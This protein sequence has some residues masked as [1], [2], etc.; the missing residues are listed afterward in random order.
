MQNVRLSELQLQE[1]LVSALAEI[2]GVRLSAA[3]S[4]GANAA[5][6][7]EKTITLDGVVRRSGSRIRI[8][9]RAI[10]ADGSVSWSEHTDGTFDD[11]FALEDALV[12]STK[13]RFKVATRALPGESAFRSTAATPKHAP[14]KKPDSEADHLVSEGLKAFRLGPS[15]AGALRHHLEV[16]AT[17][18]KRAL[19][20]EPRNA[21]GLCAYGNL[22]YVMGVNGLLPREEAFAKG[23][24]LIFAALAADDRSAEVHS[25]LG[26]LALYFD[27]DFHAAARHIH[28]SLELDPD[29][30]EALRVQSIVYKILG[31][32]DEAIQ[33][34]RDAIARSPDVAVL[35]NALGDALL[36]AGRNAEAVDALR[37]A[38]SLA[39]SYAPAQERLEIARIRLGELELAAE[40]RASR[41]AV[42]GQRERA[43]M[44]QSET[45]ELGAAEAIQRDVKRALDA[46][47][48]QAET[49]NPFAEYFATRSLADRIVMGFAEL[50]DWHHAMDWVERAYESRPGR[51]RRMLTD[52]PFDRRGLA[53]DPRYARLLRVAS[54]DDLL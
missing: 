27:D 24:E 32:I 37:H 35:W 43:A 13:T 26:K 40:M 51:L 31:R 34:A 18:Y 47:L 4:Q 28:R 48:V 54:M 16:A 46:A 39:Q 3:K 30:A 10:S 38:I 33:A 21:R 29:D 42:S 52:L 1:A 11:V 12:E 19:D 50:G 49:M 45:V 6:A 17:Y 36:A 44:I 15:G 23:R 8:T 7:N 5:S 9:M 25:S 20:I 2:P 53:V 41:L 22:H 14:D